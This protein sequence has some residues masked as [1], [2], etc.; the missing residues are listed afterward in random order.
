[1]WHRCTA[2]TIATC[3]VLLA[4]EVA[5][6]DVGLTVVTPERL[7]QLAD[8]LQVRLG[9]ED[10]TPN[11]V[12]VF[13]SGP[14]AEDV[15]VSATLVLANA[16]G[17]ERLRVPIRV[18]EQPRREPKPQRAG[19]NSTWDLSCQLHRDLVADA[20]IDVLF[21]V[22]AKNAG[23]VYRIVINDFLEQNGDVRLPAKG[24]E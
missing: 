9:S 1:M 12:E 19:A 22:R 11:R 10:R 18:N 4:T 8:R 21:D 13:V 16:K 23:R 20:K 2:V 3:M 14:T 7:A 15:V 17:E 24:S 5:R 6:G